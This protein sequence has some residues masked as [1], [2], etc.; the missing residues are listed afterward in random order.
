MIVVK[1]LFC[2]AGYL[3]MR[4][5]MPDTFQYG[6]IAGS[7]M[8]ALLTLLDSFSGGW[9]NAKQRAKTRARVK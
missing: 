6:Y 4:Q 3:V 8:V 2:V 1:I 5:L 7:L 9:S